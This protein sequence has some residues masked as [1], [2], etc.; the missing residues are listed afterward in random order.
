MRCCPLPPCGASSTPRFR[1]GVCSRGSAGGGAGTAGA[2]LWTWRDSNSPPR[3]CERRALPDELQAQ[4]DPEVACHT[5]TS[6]CSRLGAKDG[7]M[8]W[9]HRGDGGIRTR[10]LVSAR[11]TLYQLSYI[12][13]DPTRFERA[14]PCL[15]SRRS[16]IELQALDIAPQPGLEPGTLRLTGACSAELSY[17]GMKAA[18]AG[19]AAPAGRMLRCSLRGHVRS[20]TRRVA[21]RCDAP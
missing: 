9:L 17:W 7:T 2:P 14:T 10:Y 19:G 16:A 13:V 15:Q 11:H 4:S 3:R 12:P 18:A 5:S 1:P 21:G 6:R 8:Q 20:S